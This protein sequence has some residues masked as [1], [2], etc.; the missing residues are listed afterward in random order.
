MPRKP[1]DAGDSD[2]AVGRGVRRRPK[3]DS[4]HPC[5]VANAGRVQRGAA[6]LFG[7][8]RSGNFEACRPYKE[9]RREMLTKPGFTWVVMSGFGN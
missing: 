2:H 8:E 4:S 5:H 6:P 9:L 7:H 3:A 1:L